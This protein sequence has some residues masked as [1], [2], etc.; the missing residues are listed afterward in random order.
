VGV[1]GVEVCC[2]GKRPFYG[3][4]VGVCWGTSV[5]KELGGSL[6]SLSKCRSGFYVLLKF[7]RRGNT[8]KKIYLIYNTAKI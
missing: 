5:L 7:R 6:L 4:L 2:G 3:P 1:V 8:Q